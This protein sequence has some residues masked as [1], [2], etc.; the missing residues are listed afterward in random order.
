[1]VNA[2]IVAHLPDQ[3]GV[4][5]LKATCTYQGSPVTM[6]IPTNA[7]LVQPKIDNAPWSSPTR[8]K[9]DTFIAAC[10]ASGEFKISA[11]GFPISVPFVMSSSK[12]GTSAVAG[13]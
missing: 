9:S 10:T 1:M 5:E 8:P 12:A 6:C 7:S 11:R 3:L 4:L 2:A 13:D